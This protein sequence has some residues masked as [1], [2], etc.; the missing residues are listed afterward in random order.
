MLKADRVDLNAI[1]KYSSLVRTSSSLAEA[2]V[3]GLFVFPGLLLVFF[4]CALVLVADLC[5]V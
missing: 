3:W 1:P 2:T 4:P 5:S